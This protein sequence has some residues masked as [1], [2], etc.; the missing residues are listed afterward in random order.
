MSPSIFFFSRTASF[1]D[2]ASVSRVVCRDSR[3]RWWFRLQ[4]K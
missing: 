3:E 4:G 1:L 2:L